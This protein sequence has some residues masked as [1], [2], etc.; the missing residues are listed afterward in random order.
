MFFSRGAAGTWVIF[1]SYGGDE[2]S[3]LLFVQRRQDS[4]LFTK[5]TSGISSRLGRAI[6]LLVE[7]RRETQFTF[8]VATVILEFLTI[9]KKSQASSPFEALNSV[10]L[11]ECQRDVRTPVQIRLG[12]RAFSRDSTGHSEIASSCEMKDEPAFKPLQRNSAFFQVRASWCP[13]PLR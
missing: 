4:C 8:L 2:T 11:S 13:F 10:C 5:D 7:V 9:L 1:S 12:P 6:R 3:K